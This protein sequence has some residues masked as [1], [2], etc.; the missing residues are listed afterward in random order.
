MVVL[1]NKVLLN[2]GQKILKISREL[3]K[4]SITEQKCALLLLKANGAMNLKTN[5]KFIYLLSPSNI[6]N[7][8]FFVDLVEV[9]ST[10]KISFLQ[11]RLKGESYKKSLSI[12]KKAKR[13]CKKFNV[14]FIINDNPYFA[15]QIGADGCHL[16]QKDMSLQKARKILKKKIIGVSCHNSIKLVKKAT[17][18]GA[19][20][21]ALGSFFKSK[22][23]QNA[24]RSKIQII[25][26]AKKVSKLPIVCIGGITDKNYKKLIL[27]KPNFLAISNYIWSNSKL[28]PKEAAK[29][30]DL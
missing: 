5:K 11:L 13:I 1:C 10:N 4:Y 27:H 9:L 29:K 20:Y 30:I 28:K 14:K 8:K 24:I 15:K 21:V 23:K 17:K 16:G 2:T 7:N 18:D 19:D 22:T 12:A 26:K 6:K 25:N 3:K